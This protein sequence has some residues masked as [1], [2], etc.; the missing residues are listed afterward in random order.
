MPR[1]P[2]APKPRASMSTFAESDTKL[3]QIRSA[4]FDGWPKHKKVK[5]GHD[6]VQSSADNPAGEPETTSAVRS[7]PNAK[8]RRPGH[9][10]PPLAPPTPLSATQLKPVS[11]HTP[12]LPKDAD[13]VK[14][15]AQHDIHSITVMPNSKM[16]SKIQQVLRSMPTL[17]RDSKSSV[18]ALTAPAKAANKCIGIAE[19]AKRELCRDDP[20]RAVYQYTGCWTR[21]ESRK[22]P[23]QS[24]LEALPGVL[25]NTATRTSSSEHYYLRDHMDDEEQSVEAEDSDGAFEDEHC[26]ERPLVRGVVCLVIYLSTKPVSR[27]HELYGEQIYRL[28]QA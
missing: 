3:P 6:A 5:I 7:Q 12:I 1:K 19:I 18:V 10:C 26:A 15:R 8:V 16:E 14:L 13:D 25:D 23:R 17:D 4:A 20:S 2:A 21:L 11:S 28:D 27:L 9:V 24:S 22:A